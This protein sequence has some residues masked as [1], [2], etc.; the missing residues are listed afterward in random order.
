MIY[1]FAHSYVELSGID[2]NWLAQEIGREKSESVIRHNK[3]N[4]ERETKNVLRK[5]FNIVDHIRGKK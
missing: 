2:Y 3:S 5:F 4:G 1:Y